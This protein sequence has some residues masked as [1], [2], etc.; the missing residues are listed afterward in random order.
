ML[1]DGT[2]ERRRLLPSGPLD[3]KLA[4]HHLH[5]AGE[6]CRA[7]ACV[8]LCSPAWQ[9]LPDAGLPPAHLAGVGWL[10]A[11]FFLAPIRLGG[12]PP[13]T[14]GAQAAEQ[15]NLRWWPSAAGSSGPAAATLECLSE[16]RRVLNPLGLGVDI[17]E[18]DVE[19]LGPRTAP[20]PSA[21]DPGSARRPY[22]RTGPRA[23]DRSARRSSSAGSSGWADAAG[24]RRRA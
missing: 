16:R 10:D 5:C 3:V 23:P 13:N 22:D 17:G 14:I 9:S 12:W 18:A 15:A 20:D 21:E 1:H 19:V 4:H 2:L 7:L 6:F 11:G 24:S 8:S